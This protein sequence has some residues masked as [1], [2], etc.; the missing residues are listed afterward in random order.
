[1]GLIF[2]PGPS[3]FL[4]KSLVILKKR[5][6][7]CV[8][9]GCVRERVKSFML[10]L[11]LSI[12]TLLI[13][14]SGTAL[15]DGWNADIVIGGPVWDPWYYPEPYYYPY[16]YP[17]VAVVPSPPTYIEPESFTPTD[18]WYYCPGSKTYYPYVTE[19]PDGWQ[20]VPAQPPSEQ[21]R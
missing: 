16:Y 18:V 3:R 7:N 9:M 4:H 8:R 15:A 6:D 10:K 11:I 2:N 20:T 21:E 1:M 12:V 14:L 19:C 13:F 5:A 17:P